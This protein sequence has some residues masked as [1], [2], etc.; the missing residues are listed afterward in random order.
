MEN[1]FGVKDLFTFLLFGVVIVMLFLSLQQYDRQWNQIQELK[2]QVS[3]LTNDLT[4]IR[5][6]I[7]EGIVARPAP[8]TGESATTN[9]TASGPDPFKSLRDAMAKPDFAKGDWMVET[10][11]TNIGKLT[12]LI[13]TDVYAT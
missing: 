8:T 12:P 4:N 5:N 9:A 7:N 6:S 2:G 13:S 1:R 3:G 11:G 10:F